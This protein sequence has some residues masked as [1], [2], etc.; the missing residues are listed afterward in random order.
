MLSP[1][2]GGWTVYPCD[3]DRRVC[4]KAILFP[5]YANT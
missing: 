4:L 3:I 5:E 2:Q 1:G